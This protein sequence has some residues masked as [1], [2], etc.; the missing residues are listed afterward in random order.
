MP[1][2]SIAT[3]LTYGEALRIKVYLNDGS[4]KE[5]RHENLPLYVTEKGN[6]QNEKNVNEVVITY[7]SQ[8]L[9]DGVQLIDTP[10]VGSVYHHNTDIAYQ[11][12]PKSDAAEKGLTKA[13]MI[14]DGRCCSGSRQRSRAFPQQS[15]KE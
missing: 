6:P 5:I 11:Y 8:Y 3:V 7:P 10:G 13:S 14:S 9:K 1:L 15:I 2:T 4:V 12:I